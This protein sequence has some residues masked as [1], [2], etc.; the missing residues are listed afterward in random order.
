[1]GT[2][3]PSVRERVEV[4]RG[5]AGGPPYGSHPPRTTVLPYVAFAYATL[6]VVA[7]AILWFT[8]P[9]LLL[10]APALLLLVVAVSAAIALA[11]SAQWFVH[12]R[13]PDHDFV[14]HNEVAGFI[15][16]VAGALYAVLLGFMTVV[17]WQHFADARQL[18]AQEAA[19]SADVWHAA[20]GLPYRLR[21]QVRSDD[22][23]YAKAMMENEWANMRYGRIDPKPDILIMDAISAAG[24][25]KPANLMESNSQL[26]TLQQL[27]AL[28]DFRI[29]RV[30]ENASGITAF[31]WI[32]LF[33]GAAC[34][35]SFCWLFGLT[36]ARVH[37]LMTG[38]VTAIIAATLVLLFELQFPFR[39]DLRIPPT[40]WVGTVDHI[41]SMQT[42]SQ[43]KMRM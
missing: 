3:D 17:A 35:I 36:N 27:N 29:R 31:E 25:F 40:L 21:T 14:Q 37:L 30:A 9:V 43:T 38:T 39:T 32:V 28:H 33:F 6:C 20:I 41:H 18:V 8:R 24:T 34:V 13:F 26:G 5:V 7:S 12:R 4:H 23:K 19:T 42:G 10:E 16:A 22:L 15:I 11:C 1:M 2:S